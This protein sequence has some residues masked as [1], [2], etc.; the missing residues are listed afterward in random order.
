MPGGWC[1]IRN[2]PLSPLIL[3]GDVEG[4]PPDFERKPV[5]KLNY[6]K[7]RVTKEEA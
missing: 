6:Y 2:P 7:T 4:K 3:R 1:A 5:E